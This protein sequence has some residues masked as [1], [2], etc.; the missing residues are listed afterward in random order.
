MANNFFFPFPPKTHGR[1]RSP[2]ELPNRADSRDE[3]ASPGRNEHHNDVANFNRAGSGETSN[4]RIR[5]PDGVLPGQEFQAYAGERIVRVRCPPDSR[6]GQSLQITVPRSSINSDVSFNS[7]NE[8]RPS[9]SQQEFP[10]SENVTR[11]PDE[12]LAP[13]E[14]AAY[15]VQIPEGVRRGQQF[16]VRIN[17]QQ[18]SVTCPESGL[19]GMK[20]RVV[21][22]P[23]AHQSTQPIV[24]YLNKQPKTQ[25]FEVVIPSGVEP[26]RPF[27]LLAGGVRVLVTCPI[28]ATSGQKIQFNLPLELISSAGSRPESKLAQIKLSYNKDGWSRTVRATDMKFQWARFDE[29]GNVDVRK[30]FDVDRS[31]Y[32][33]KLDYLNSDHIRGGRVSL[34]TPEKGV[35]DSSIRGADG[36]ELASYSDIANAQMKSYN[37][38]ID[39]FQSTCSRLAVTD[40]KIMM[41]IRRDYLMCDSIQA[42]MSLSRE[43]LRKKWIFHFIGEDG[44]DVGGLTRE[45]FELV[46]KAMFDPNMGLWQMSETNQMCMRI[47]PA[48]AICCPEDHLVCFRFIGRVLGRALFDGQLVNGHMVKYLYKHL[49]RWPVMFSDLRDQDEGYFNSLKQLNDMGADVRHV[50]VDFTATEELLGLNRTVDLIPGGAGIEVTE[51]N[52]PEYIESCLRYRLLGR[53]EAQL[54]ELL[55]GFYDVLPEPLLAIF[56]FQELEL[57]MC[58]LPEIEMDDW[59]EHTEYTGEYDA[60][61]PDHEVCVWFWEIVSEYDREMKA[62]L[63]QFVTG[64]S[65]V[66]A[67][68]FCCLQGND[69]NIRRFTI[70]GVGLDTCIYP[71]S[72]TCFN[73]IDLPLYKMKKELEEKL[74]VAITMAATGFDLE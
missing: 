23:L 59:M 33:L 37:D 34:V 15:N 40:G 30:R 62:R 10:D 41:K 29:R 4:F 61:G 13:G 31:A 38:K 47:N 58:G 67:S 8:R 14:Q 32:V 5:I 36:S 28:N 17:G 35:V 43:E 3:H 56:D 27:T 71:R 57:L 16:P 54:N 22:P 66:P 2:I 7:F 44:L 72:H 24:A 63:L 6:P 50:G 46:S 20:V 73:R 69:G 45:W 1:R 68:G 9:S 18:L 51:D 55:L 26:G 12:H 64:T 48:S 52:L 49:L 65:G 19:P 53:C 60:E 74:R 42:V 11:I 70:E 25:K 21:P 39:W